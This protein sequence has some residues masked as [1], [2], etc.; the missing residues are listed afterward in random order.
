M[1]YEYKPKRQNYRA[2]GA[3]LALA[4]LA[5]AC[6]VGAGFMPAYGVLV[7]SLAIILFVPAIYLTGKYLI[8]RYLYRVRTLEDGSVD[9]DISAY[10][11]GTKMQLVGRVGLCEITRVARLDAGNRRAAKGMERYTYCADISPDDAMV[12]SITNEDGDCELLLAYNDT[13]YRL[14]GGV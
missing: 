1:D 13:L 2:H 5:I 8:T 12:V 10:R 9:L 7:Q 14:L 4:I 3:V 11:G 6:L